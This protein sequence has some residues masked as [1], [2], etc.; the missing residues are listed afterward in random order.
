[1]L[2]AVLNAYTGSERDAVLLRMK[3]W[4]LLD[5]VE[6]THQELIRGNVASVRTGLAQVRRELDVSAE[7]GV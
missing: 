1:M 5:S 4:Y 2:E 6:W 7:S 3:S